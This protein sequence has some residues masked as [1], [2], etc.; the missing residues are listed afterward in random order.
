MKLYECPRNCKIRLIGK[1]GKPTAD[2]FQFD[3]VDGMYSLCF[4]DKDHPVHLAAW[5]DVEIVWDNL[6]GA[7]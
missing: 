3:H 2:V 6:E 7:P 4:D 5:T 1:D